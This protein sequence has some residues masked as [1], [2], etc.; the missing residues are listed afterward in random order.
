MLGICRYHRNA[1][2]WNDIGYNALVDR[3]GNIYAGRAGGISKPVV[4]AQAQGFNA[5]T[6]GSRRSAPTPRSRHPQAG[7]ALVDCLSWKLAVIG[8]NAIGKT[9]LVS[10]G[11]DLSRYRAGRRVRLNRVFGHGTVGLTACP[12]DGAR[13]RDPEDPPPD[14]GADPD[15]VSAPGVVT[16][17]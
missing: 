10:A 3:F 7:S 15:A 17:N 16:P 11:G 2:G 1:N 14:P 9:T 4:G 8:L 13:R 6:T 12:G 5:Q